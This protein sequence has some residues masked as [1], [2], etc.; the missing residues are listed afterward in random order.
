M[1]TDL[2]TF[3]PLYADQTEAV[4]LER[5]REW[6]NEGRD[7]GEDVDQWTD[8]REGSAWWIH[9]IGGIREAARLYDYAGTEVVAAAFPQWSWGEKLDDHGELRGTDR[10]AA[11]AAT[12]TVTLTG[13]A[14]AVIPIGTVVGVEPS[15]PGAE[16]PEFQTTEEVTL[17]GGSEDVD[18]EA[19]EAGTEGNVAA[20]AI[21]VVVTANEDLDSVTNAAATE[22]GTDTE[23]DEAFRARI[24]ESYVGAAVANQVY[25]RR[26]ALNQDGIGR[27]TVI[28]AWDGPGTVLIVVSTAEGGAVSAGVLSDFQDLVDPDSGGGIGEGQTGA[29]ITVTTT[30]TLAIDVAGV[31]E[32]E[33]GFSMEGTGGTVG[34][35]DVIEAV[36]ETYISSVSPGS[37]IVIARVAAEIMKL[38]GVHDLKN[39]TL[40]GGAVNVAVPSDPVAQVPVLD[41]TASLVEG[42][43][44]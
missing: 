29:V 43:V 41:D 3:D 16:A 35:R 25:Y 37:E 39:L 21:T 44:P 26:L 15:E 33:S 18:V 1:A 17:T 13:T 5:W 14:D 11:T 20:G 30:T 28:N 9:T 34:L 32:F 4:I 27:A 40:N 42:A 6:A 7:P 19:V 23:N 12:G 2:T 10:L 22:G 8:T 38:R 36:I 24:L 31:V